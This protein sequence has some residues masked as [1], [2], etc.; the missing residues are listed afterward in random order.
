MRRMRRLL[1]P[2]VLLLAGL[3]SGCA[4]NQADIRGYNLISIEDEKQLGVKFA[5]EIEKQYTVVNDP[6]LQGYVD[7]LGKRLLTGAREVSFDYT[8]KAVK[9]DS[10]NAFAIPGGH[11][12]VNTGL[13]KTAQSETE[14]A[15]VMAHE[16]NHAVARHGTRQLTQQF[17]Y[18]LLLQ[19]VLGDN[20]NLLSQLAASMFGKAGFMAYGRGMESQADYLGVETMYRSGYNPDGMLTFFAKLDAIHQESPGRLA[21]FF[22]SHPLTGERI[23]R[24]REEIAKLPQRSYPFTGDNGEFRKIQ[25]RVR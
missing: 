16:I 7:R 9:D 10:V 23:R 3:G 18:S 25:G 6:E 17:G 24:V 14:L 5:T 4:V 15:G 8:F 21:Q 11:I 22:S 1:L 12:Y 20:P 2:F 19:L 13:I